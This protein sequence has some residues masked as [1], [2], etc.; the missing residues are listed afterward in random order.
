MRA[1]R[2]QP[3]ITSTRISGRTFLMCSASEIPS[4]WGMS[5][6]IRRISI[7]FGWLYANVSAS[8]WSAAAKTCKP[9]LSRTRRTTLRTPTSSSA[10]STIQSYFFRTTYRIVAEKTVGR[11]CVNPDWYVTA[12]MLF[13]RFDS[14]YQPG[15]Q[16]A[17]LTGEGALLEDPRETILVV[18]DEPAMRHV[19][20]RTL[21]VAGY[22]VLEASSGAEAMELARSFPSAIHLAIID[23]TLGDS[24]GAS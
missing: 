8:S 2:S 15:Q 7:R 14:P 17:P 11:Y 12:P 21:T 10:N 13:G 18:D 1:E 6:S 5:T 4:S 3:D 16:P 24:N 20:I 22:F 19:M 23:Q 9:A